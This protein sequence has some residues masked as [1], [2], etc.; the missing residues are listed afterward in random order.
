MY[1]PEQ[2]YQ[3]NLDELRKRSNGKEVV[4]L[5]EVAQI[6]GFKDARTVKKKYPFVGGYIS[7]ATL[8][9]C[10]TPENPMDCSIDN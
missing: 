1:T 5:R 8:A 9:R 6:L 10:L 3:D 2:F 4:N 7:L